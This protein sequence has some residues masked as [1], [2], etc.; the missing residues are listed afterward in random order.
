MFDGDGFAEL[1]ATVEQMN[2]FLGLI[3][4]EKAPAILDRISRK[5]FS[6]LL[7]VL[8]LNLLLVVNGST[9]L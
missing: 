7:L 6:I 3:H 1:A 4:R 5:L 2:V 9:V 8:F